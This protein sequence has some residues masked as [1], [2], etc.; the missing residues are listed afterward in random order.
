MIISNKQ[1][2]TDIILSFRQAELAL[3]SLKTALKRAI[4]EEDWE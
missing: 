2:R 4:D 3:A 1:T